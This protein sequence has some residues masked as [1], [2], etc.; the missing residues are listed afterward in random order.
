MGYPEI[1]TDP[2]P[3]RYNSVVLVGPDGT[4]LANYRKRH[5]YYTDETWASEGPNDFF[6]ANLPGLGRVAM[7]ICESWNADRHHLH[8]LLHCLDWIYHLLK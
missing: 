6:V 2:V 1:T 3:V 7:G 4:V 8:Q 5:L